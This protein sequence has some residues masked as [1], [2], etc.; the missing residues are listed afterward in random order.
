[1]VDIRHGVAYHAC[2]GYMVESVLG[3]L[4]QV[5]VMS[6]DRQH[7][8]LC[9]LK[10]LVISVHE[11]QNAPPAESPLKFLLT[12]DGVAPDDCYFDHWD[13]DYES[14]DSFLMESLALEKMPSHDVEIDL[15]YRGL[16]TSTCRARMY[17]S[18]TVWRGVSVLGLRRGHAVNLRHGW[19]KPLNPNDG[20]HDSC[21]ILSSSV[22]DDLDPSTDSCSYDASRSMNLDG[23][24]SWTCPSCESRG[25]TRDLDSALEYPPACP[26]VAIEMLVVDGLGRGRGLVL[27]RGLGLCC[28]LCSWVGAR[29]AS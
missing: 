29:G 27:A 3:V 16:W 1:M 5:L 7:G 15:V 4:S 8:R 22:C 18:T 11:I 17:V 21:S 24:P 2:Y 14:R 19:A 25:V 23:R 13:F 6:P 12:G 26:S 20:G 28:A 10:A 9:T